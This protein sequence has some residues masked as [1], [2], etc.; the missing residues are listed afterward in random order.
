MHE[1]FLS[2]FQQP[3]FS[4]LDDDNTLCVFP[5][6]TIRRSYLNSYVL[7]SDRGVIL[8]SRALAWDTFTSRFHSQGERQSANRMAR[9]LFVSSFLGT[10]GDQLEWFTQK[11][12]PEA[13]RQ[14]LPTLVAL[15][16]YLPQL[17]I[18][19]S[20]DP[21]AYSRIPLQ[22]RNDID[23][24][25][26]SYTSFLESSN[27][28]DP[29]YCECTLPQ[30]FLASYEK[31]AI[32]FPESCASFFEYQRELEKIPSCTLYRAEKSRKAVLYR[33]ENERIELHA[34][35]NEVRGLLDKGTHPEDIA[36]SVG[37][38]TR[39]RPYMARFAAEYDID[40]HFQSGYHLSDYPS[41]ILFLR[42]EEVVSRDF[43]FESVKQ[44]LLDRKIPWKERS[45]HQTIIKRA[46]ALGIRQLVPVSKDNQWNRLNDSYLKKL[47]S[48]I[49]SCTRAKDPETIIGV[50]NQLMSEYL[51]DSW[52]YSGDSDIQSP[53][54]QA[55]SATV[56][57]LVELEKMISLTGRNESLSLFSLFVTL[58]KKESFYPSGRETGIA[59]YE[60]PSGAGIAPPFHFFMNCT[61][62]SVERKR[63]TLPLLSNSVLEDTS[64]E[65]IFDAALLSGDSC[66]FS[67]ALSGYSG[68]VALPPSVF[69]S[70][71]MSILEGKPVMSREM[72][73]ELLWRTGKAEGTASERQYA[74]YH[75]AEATAFRTKQVDI[76]KGTPYPVWDRI[77]DDTGRLLLSATALDMME[78]CPAKYLC[79]HVFRLRKGEWS[80]KELDHSIIGSIQ[81]EILAQF[82]R[83]VEDQKIEGNGEKRSFLLSLIERKRSVLENEKRSFS[84]Y[85]LRFITQVFL[86]RLQD[87]IERESALFG[88]TETQEIEVTLRKDLE[89]YPVTL[90]GRIDRIFSYSDT[91][92][93]SIG[94][95]DYKKS[96]PPPLTPFKAGSYPLPSYQLPLY[97]QV[98]SQAESVGDRE[99]TSGT[100]YSIKNGK[101]HQIWSDQ[102]LLEK[103]K[104]A[105]DE[106]VVLMIT[107][108]KEG[109]LKAQ[110]SKKS[111]QYCDYRQI[112]RR[113]YVLP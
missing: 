102:P 107:R 71:G 60:Y 15:L 86:L 30:E 47:F 81:H 51:S 98:A 34:L 5:S 42:M 35:Y 96:D 94:I 48:L 20:S 63:D 32:I 79:S 57:L 28:F 43:S 78:S 105:L 88:D 10:I 66:Y 16:D 11:T 108:L 40:L 112:C 65:A 44:F 62:L 39:L 64:E 52:D 7:R 110:V 74:G 104:A 106:A 89:E 22:Y 59:V 53:L 84:P 23:L 90:E 24:V 95:L 27:L 87:I 109:D 67:Y 111:C 85:S 4:L 55:F 80:I 76:P 68:T 61:S 14:Y 1:T 21:E 56:Q 72:S 73:E 49:N 33:F 12:F 92:E 26:S 13:Q 31:V 38:I 75:A 101:F 36:I 6:E 70:Q 2:S 82:Y 97:A 37:D 17:A 8:P 100:Y 69:L 29:H 46:I 99:V 18:L 50:V 3:V 113:R 19:R 41:G 58:L 25:R 91:G 54:S 77:I 103:L 83:G 45:R 93:S 9:Y